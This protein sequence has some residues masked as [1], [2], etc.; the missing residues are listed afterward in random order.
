MRFR[1]YQADIYDDQSIIVRNPEDGQLVLLTDEEASAL[2]Y[3]ESVTVDSVLG[4]LLPDAGI[5]KK[6][7][8]RASL[9]AIAKMK[10]A[11]LLDLPAIDARIKSDT[12]TMEIE[13]SRKKIRFSG[14]DSM[15]ATIG[16]LFGRIFVALRAPGIL[17]FAS[18]FAVFSVAFFPFGD[19]E[20]FLISGPTYS[21][22]LIGTYLIG[23]LALSFRSVLQLAFLKVNGRDVDEVC[24]SLFGPFVYIRSIGTAN[25]LLGVRGRFLYSLIGLLSPLALS[26]IFVALFQLQAISLAA[27]WT[28]FAACVGVFL[29]L[30]CPLVRADGAD[31][32]NIFFYRYNPRASTA[33]DARDALMQK[34]K[35]IS[36]TAGVALLASLIWFLFYLDILRA[37]W[38][39][40]AYRVIPDLME[41]ANGEVF[42]AAAA[43][44]MGFL[45]LALLP[46]V[47]SLV[48]LLKGIVWQ[49]K[50][51]IIVPLPEGAALEL[52]F[53]EQMSALEKVPLFAALESQER[54][55][56][57][58]EMQLVTFK[59]GDYLVRQG[60]IGHDFFVLIR[61]KAQ[62]VFHDFQGKKH[63]V[64]ELQEGD[65]FGEIALL[66]DVPRTASVVSVTVSN[67]LVL[68]KTS[69]DKVVQNL[70]SPE[71]VKQ[72]IR[73]TSFF[74]RHPLFSKLSPREQADLIHA[75]NFELLA[76]GEEVEKDPSDDHFYV[77]YSG[78]L[79]VD[80]G[81]DA[82]DTTIESDDCFGYA[83]GISTKIT[84]ADG[85][86]LLRIRKD[87]FDAL[88]WQ[89]LVE[90]PDLFI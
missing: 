6:D 42:F 43:A 17:I 86:G 7:H 52:D 47:A 75:F 10:R 2:R 90:R 66:D 81:D 33:V 87:Q 54:L 46:P 8:I 78:K 79:K 31:I 11:G 71:K 89:K 16:G 35:S 84:T 59:A 70:G 12:M 83:Q 49:R 88:I 62:A 41:P 4:I 57:F 9:S 50:K 61:G 72:M 67:V 76:P 55:A 28:V 39:V 13:I 44:A 82:T 29:M 73:L 14:L 24:F 26:G 36:R 74:R 30:L 80:T 48:L 15:A 19:K 3:M 25:W 64:N 69:F 56:L 20:S 22:L 45:G 32:L 34:V 38:N 5:A 40:W 65:A 21:S 53:D 27:V 85:A 23:C 51:S 60:E 58:N 18:A 1:S 77:V 63:I 68:R 37:Y